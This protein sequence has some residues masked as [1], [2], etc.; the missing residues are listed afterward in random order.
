MAEEDAVQLRLCRQRP[1]LGRPPRER[2]TAMRDRAAYER[3][4]GGVRVLAGRPA[5]G[6]APN[7]DRLEPAQALDRLGGVGAEEHVVAAQHEALCARLAGVR[8]HG[9][10]RR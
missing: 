3:A 8:E 9:L 5:I 4:V 2:H 10:E 1:E 6:V 7:P